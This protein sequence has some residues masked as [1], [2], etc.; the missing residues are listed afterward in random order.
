MWLVISGTAFLIGFEFNFVECEKLNWS[1]CANCWFFF[2][3]FGDGNPH[4]L[5]IGKESMTSLLFLPN[6]EIM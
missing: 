5:Y 4:M 3:V 6:P 1:G 2:Y